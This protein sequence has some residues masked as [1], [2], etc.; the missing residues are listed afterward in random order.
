M[1]I[2]MITP[3]ISARRKQ[4]KEIAKQSKATKAAIHA[5]N[6]LL[7]IY[8]ISRPFARFVGNLN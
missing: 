6:V 7:M 1:T 8:P 3:F 5:C 2:P 4:L